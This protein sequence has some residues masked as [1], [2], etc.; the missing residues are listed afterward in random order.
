MTF[1]IDSEEWKRWVE[2]EVLI[3]CINME[4][5]WHSA[6]LDEAGDDTEQG[7]IHFNG[8]K[9][10]VELRKS[11][12]PHDESTVIRAWRTLDDMKTV[13]NQNDNQLQHMMS[14]AQN[15]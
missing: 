1:F 15:E 5:A 6:R 2:Y 3:E 12:R 4:V 10:A 14:L 11:L 13:R 7:R 9:A 8:I